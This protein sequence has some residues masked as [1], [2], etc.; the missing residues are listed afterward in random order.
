MLAGRPGLLSMCAGD[1][2]EV[3]GAHSQAGAWDCVA[4]CF[5]L[6]TAHNIVQYMEVI[7]HCLK[8]GPLSDKPS[9]ESYQA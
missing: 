7:R 5:F 9:P 2:V 3:Y 4:T 1:F 6:D 8:V